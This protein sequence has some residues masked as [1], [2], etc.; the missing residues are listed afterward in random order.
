MERFIDPCCKKCTHTN[1]TPCKDFITCCLEGPVCH[2]D[3]S[4]SEKRKRLIKKVELH[5]HFV[6]I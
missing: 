3:Q 5:E 6:I 4:C 1:V 2:Q